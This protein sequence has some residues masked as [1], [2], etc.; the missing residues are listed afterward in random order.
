MKR[1][2]SFLLL[3]AVVQTVMA[4]DAIVTKDSERIDAKIVRVTKT[5]VRYRTPDGPR[6]V[7][8]IP[9][10]KVSSVIYADGS[11]RSFE[12]VDED[13]S[14][15]PTGE[16]AATGNP[17]YKGLMASVG[18]QVRANLGG[19]LD[20]GAGVSAGGFISGNSYWGIN[21]SALY[22]Y[23]GRKNNINW[24]LGV[25]NRIYALVDDYA[26]YFVDLYA[27][28]E[29]FTGGNN[30]QRKET[31][32]AFR[33]MPGVRFSLSPTV[34]LRVS[35]GYMSYFYSSYRE[36]MYGQYD[37]AAVKVDLDIH[38]AFRMADM[39]KPA[40][41]TRAC[42]IQLTTEARMMSKIY[43]ATFA[44]GYLI[45]PNL[46]A[47]IG[48]TY[49][50]GSIGSIHTEGRPDDYY[51]DYYSYDYQV[52]D[53]YRLFARVNYRILDGTVSPKVS[54][55]FGR[56]HV[57]VGNNGGYNAMYAS[58]SAGAS[59]RLGKNTYLDLSV[60]YEKTFSK[61]TPSNDGSNAETLNYNDI[62]AYSKLPAGLYFSLGVTHTLNL[63]TL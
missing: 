41:Q 28:K 13:D 32:L 3:F 56:K 54:L 62:H 31:A 24:M 59:L 58:P 46:S 18:T 4:Q 1:L 51:D 44:P 35:A 57:N 22:P 33:V 34:D 26:D 53:F 40:R 21:V 45:T 17:Q 38:H 15:T 14:A 61:L 36:N 25:E 7:Q 29:F 43:G 20:F 30:S 60:G 63:L 48:F 42:G 6:G 39:V 2:L 9:T 5:E 37:G 50:H 55:D 10:A 27:G 23:K 19:N 8:T 12:N 52:S 16:T 11:V 49:C 47:G